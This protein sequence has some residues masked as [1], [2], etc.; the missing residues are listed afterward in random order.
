MTDMLMLI[1]YSL[2]KEENMGGIYPALRLRIIIVGTENN[3]H[4][5]R[6]MGKVVAN[7]IDP[8]DWWEGSVTDL[9][10]QCARNPKI[11]I[12]LGC[13]P[14]SGNYWK[15]KCHGY[16]LQTIKRLG[17]VVAIGEC[18]LD[19]TLVSRRAH[20]RSRYV[21]IVPWEKQE[22]AFRGQVH[23]ALELNLPLVIHLREAEQR[24]RDVLNS[25][26]PSDWKL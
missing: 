26:L 21:T 11:Y 5:R 15:N 7:F 25:M 19:A 1:D 13:H 16:L 3:H 20:A 4:L 24:G 6:I 2:G 14:Q 23:L 12:T 22:A 18:G 9:M 10:I 8:T 17:H